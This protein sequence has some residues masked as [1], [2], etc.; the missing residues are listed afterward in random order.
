[1]KSCHL[2]LV[3][4]LLAFSSSVPQLARS[5]GEDRPA[6]QTATSAQRPSTQVP[7][8]ATPGQ[9]PQTA[10]SEMEW[11][12]TLARNKKAD[13]TISAENICHGSHQFHLE[14]V[15]LPFMQFLATVDFSVPPRKTHTV[16]VRFDTT[17]LAPG[18]YQGRVNILCTSC[19]REPGCTQDRSILNVFMTVPGG[20]PTWS[21]VQPAQK[22]S[23]AGN[24]SLKWSDIDLTRKH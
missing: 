2:I 3:V 8:Q 1:M 23:A 24:P 12:F 20:A 13:T 11:R 6:S 16:P 9:P 17:G 21:N 4:F 15:N 19:R 10:P 5:A 18:L 14:P 22:P 7:Q